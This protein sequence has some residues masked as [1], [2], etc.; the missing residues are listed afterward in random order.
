[1]KRGGLEVA[2]LSGTTHHILRT[3]IGSAGW[4]TRNAAY[5][6]KLV[7]KSI[8][9]TKGTTSWS[10]KSST[11]LPRRHSGQIRACCDTSRCKQWVTYPSRLLCRRCR[12]FLLLLPFK[13]KRCPFV[14]AWNYH[15]NG[16][17]EGE[18]EGG[19]S[20]RHVAHQDRRLDSFLLQV[21]IPLGNISHTKQGISAVGTRQAGKRAW[22]D[23][24]QRGC[25]V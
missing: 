24:W 16:K 11:L 25:G 13:L 5:F 19:C 2:F 6:T 17:A 10:R 15:P 18:R 23:P 3:Q 9:K 1:M 22:T 12:L 8:L 4:S 7:A 20:A 21:A 14:I